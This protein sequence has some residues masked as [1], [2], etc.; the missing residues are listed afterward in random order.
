MKNGLID[1]LMTYLAV[2]IHLLLL[3]TSSA[4]LFEKASI[5]SRLMFVVE[6]FL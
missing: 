3:I 5:D 6:V 1:L 4:S 2:Y